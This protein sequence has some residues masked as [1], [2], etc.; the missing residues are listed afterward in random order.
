MSIVSDLTL[1]LV[2]VEK[3]PSTATEYSFPAVA[4]SVNDWF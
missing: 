4:L 2:L 3:H 1:T